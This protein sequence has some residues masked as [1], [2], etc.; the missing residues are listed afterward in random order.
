MP[1]RLDP[2]VPLPVTVA[3]VA[4]S[5]V[6]ALRADLK[7]PRRRGEVESVH[8]ARKRA[9][10]L[11]AL[12]RLVRPALGDLYGASNEVFRDTARELSELRNSQVLVETLEALCVSTPVALGTPA[13]SEARS[14]A[15][16]RHRQATER[17]AAADGPLA[18]A[19]R[20]SAPAG[21]IIGQWDLP[22]DFAAVGAGFG[23]TYGRATEAFGRCLDER[24]AGAFHEL[25][26]RVKYHRY[27]LELLSSIGGG[28]IEPWA[29]RLHDLTDLLGDDHDL[30]E[31]VAVVRSDPDAFGGEEALDAIEVLA[32]GRSAQLR[33]SALALGSRLTAEDPDALVARLEKWWSAARRYG[34]ATGPTRLADLGGGTS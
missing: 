32:A 14:E 27:Q 33:R 24:S 18:R 34:N 4:R 15:V 31:L 12:T 3:E 19:R 9:K 25:R 11:R 17:L 2:S 22:D 20:A 23:N 6:K 5:Q 8:D 13:L 10:K 26:K 30:W 7:H 29:D 28:L 1:Y 16:A 21:E